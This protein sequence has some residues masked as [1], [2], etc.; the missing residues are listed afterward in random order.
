VVRT[1]V[2]GADLMQL[3]GATCTSPTL[4]EDQTIRLLPMILDGLRT[5]QVAS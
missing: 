5:P 3:I 1:D 4:S 2:D